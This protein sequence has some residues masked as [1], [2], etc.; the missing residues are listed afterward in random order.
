MSEGVPE[1]PQSPQKRVF[2]ERPEGSHAAPLGVGSL[3]PINRQRNSPSSSNPTNKSSQ[4]YY[5][6]PIREKLRQ[7]PFLRK[8]I[9]FK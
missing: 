9:K 5:P 1:Q 6:N 2:A 7:I 3:E 8:I 4:I